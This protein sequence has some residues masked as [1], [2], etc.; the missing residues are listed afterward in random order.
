MSLE[1]LKNNI[2]KEKQIVKSIS[3]LSQRIKTM[4]PEERRF[5]LKSLNSFI[6]QLKILNDALPELV[7]NINFYKNLSKKESK[8]D[9]LVNVSYQN[10]VNKKSLAI[11][12]EDHYNFLKSIFAENK[13]QGKST[14]YAEFSNKF[15][16]K[17][18]FEIS[19]KSYI[20]FLKE[21]LRKI[22]SPYMVGTYIAMALMTATIAFIFGI[23]F[24]LALLLFK[25]PFIVSILV[26]FFLPILAFFVFILYP[27]STRKS[28]EK[29][30]NQELPFLTIYMAAIATSGIEPSKIFSVIASSRDY[31]FTQREVKKLIN[32]VNFYGYDL[33]NALKNVS[34]NCPSERLSQL[35]DGLAT[36]ITSGGE[37]TSFLSKHSESLLFDYR[38]E[39]E[40]Y[41]RIAETFMDIYISVIIAAPMMLLMLFMLMSITGFNQ[42]FLDPNMLS[43]LTILLIS[44]L[45][46]GFLLFLNFKQLKF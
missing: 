28:L 18:S 26:I 15:F 23:V 17:I 21:D 20:H 34:K 13:S 37:L 5:S 39:R 2:A 35:F 24:G 25:V 42:S 33:V 30:I 16:S 8:N 1:L 4:D 40:K 9:N 10:D 7:N 38:L 12:K 36:T 6:L 11:K 31:P 29:S 41:T 44:V 14:A 3:V 19:Q 46:I 45:N 43:I 32:Y 27:S 22:T